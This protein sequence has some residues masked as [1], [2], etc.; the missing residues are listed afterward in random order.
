MCQ[1][2]PL[3][4]FVC[5]FPLANCPPS[6]VYM[7]HAW[8]NSV[9]EHNSVFGVVLTQLHTK[10]PHL[11]HVVFVTST[12]H[13]GSD[14]LSFPWHTTSHSVAIWVTKVSPQ[15]SHLHTQPGLPLHLSSLLC[16]VCCLWLSDAVVCVGSSPSV[17]HCSPYCHCLTSC[18]A[19]RVLHLY[20]GRMPSMT[21]SATS[22]RH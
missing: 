19:H 13:C 9:R 7:V 17:R 5:C 21:P 3:S 1:L 11:C 2:L 12:L 10:C 14:E 8:H 18:C 6:Y 22:V 20:V 4:Q 16:L 15:P